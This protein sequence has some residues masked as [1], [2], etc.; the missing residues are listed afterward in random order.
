MPDKFL[1]FL[2]GGGRPTPQTIRPLAKV[3]HPTPRRG[4]VKGADFELLRHKSKLIAGLW[5]GTQ[6]TGW[7]YDESCRHFPRA[8]SMNTV[9]FHEHL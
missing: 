5:V 7:G 6:M 4:V 1:C 2:S 8:F 3:Q 9:S